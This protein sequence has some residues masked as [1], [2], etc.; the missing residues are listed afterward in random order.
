[1][2]IGHR[3]NT[4]RNKRS[5]AVI[6]QRFCDTHNLVELPAD[7]WQ[8]CCYAMYMADRVTAHGTVNNYVTGVRNLQQLAGYE[9]PELL[10]P[11]LKLI[12]SGIKAYL[13]KPVK[14]AVPMNIDILKDIATLVDQNNQFQMAA[15]TAILTGFYLILRC[16]NLVPTST[17][18]FNSFEQ[19]SRWNAGIDKDGK[20][21]IF[22]IEWSKTIQHCKKELCVLVVLAPEGSIC[23]VKTLCKY[24]TLV[25]A[26]QNDP[27]FCYRNKHGVLNA[28][29]YKQ[30]NMQ[31]KDW[32]EATGRDPQ[33]YTTHCLR[34]GELHTP[35]RWE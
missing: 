6:Y 3:P 34:R 26:K 32:V 17:S 9:S 21:V 12:M 11:N 5:Q 28:L 2:K 35:S 24:F 15:Y 14:E 10:S 23:L 8:L 30:L 4:R 18:T 22:I 19:F 13:A 1:M 31:L 33:G 29:T 7:E 16:S 27:R 25:P 20:L